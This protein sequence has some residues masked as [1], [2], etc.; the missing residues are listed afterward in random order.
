MAATLKTFPY[1]VLS[2]TNR[3][4]A[5]TRDAE[6]AAAMVSVLGDG[7]YVMVGRR[8]VWTEGEDADGF[9]GESYDEAAG[10]MI[11]RELAQ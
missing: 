5:R 7:A 3:E 8:V 6:M 2:D 9:A 11:T 4:E 1:R 10:V